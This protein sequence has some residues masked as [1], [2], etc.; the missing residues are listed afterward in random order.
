MRVRRGL[1]A[2]PDELSEV[3][4][5]AYKQK[6][7]MD[8]GLFLGCQAHTNACSVKWACR[9]LPGVVKVLG[10]MQADVLGQYLSSKRY[11]TGTQENTY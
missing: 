6:A 9:R 10:K 8:S 4:I 2:L 3:N 7:D 11:F 1:P 5:V